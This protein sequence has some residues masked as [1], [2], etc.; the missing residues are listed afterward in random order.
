MSGIEWPSVN[1]VVPS[2]CGPGAA[3]DPGVPADTQTLMPSEF[4]VVSKLTPYAAQMRFAVSTI[5]ATPAS[6]TCG[7]VYIFKRTTRL[8]S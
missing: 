7:C 8:A 1:I 6:A 2:T 3:S 4:V 5:R